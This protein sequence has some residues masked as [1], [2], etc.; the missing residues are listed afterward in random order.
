[1]PSKQS[2]EKTTGELRIE[3]RDI[4]KAV[5]AI[6]EDYQQTAATLDRV[7]EDM[8]GFETTNHAANVDALQRDLLESL[9][10]ESASI[11]TPWER[12]G[13]DTKEAWT[14]AT[15]GNT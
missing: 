10:N 7:T 1:M 15:E 9:S 8:S 2:Q 14:Q 4:R 6:L 11:T 3:L 13:Y 12:A 5:E